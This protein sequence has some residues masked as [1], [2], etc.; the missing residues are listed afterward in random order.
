MEN[1]LMNK[2]KENYHFN[3]IEEIHDNVIEL[4]ADM[5]LSNSEIVE[6]LPIITKRLDQILVDITEFKK[7]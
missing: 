4:R 5:D 2:N 3:L 7:L 6:L 1:S